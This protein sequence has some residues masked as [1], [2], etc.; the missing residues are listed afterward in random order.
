VSEAATPH[1]A[2]VI[3]LVANQTGLPPAKIAPT[4]RLREDLGVDGDDAEELLEAIR[5]E[6]GVDFADFKLARFFACEPHLFSPVIRLWSWLRGDEPLRSMTVAHL[7]RVALSRAWFEPA[8][9]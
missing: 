4:S 1:L 2:Q 6:F 3:G 9:D 8:G 5:D 7:A